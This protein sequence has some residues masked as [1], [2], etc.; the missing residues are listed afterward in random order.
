VS[1]SIWKK[2]ISFKKKPKATVPLPA[3]TVP[4]QQTAP[5]VHVAKS[6]SIWKKEIGFKKKAKPPKPAAPAAA[7]VEK[8]EKGESIWKKEIGRKKKTEQEAPSAAP[9][10]PA[11]DQQDEFPWLEERLRWWNKEIGGSR[12]KAEASAQ[13]A[14]FESA[15]QQSREPELPKMMQDVVDAVVAQPVEEW[16]AP[17]AVP[18]API[19]PEHVAEPEVASETEAAAPAEPEPE[20]EPEAPQTDEPEPAPADTSVWKKEIGFR[21]KPKQPKQPK[22]EKPKREKRSRRKQQPEQEQQEEPREDNPAE[23]KARRKLPNP[24]LSMPSRRKA[25]RGTDRLVGLKIG[26]SQIAAA[27]IANNGVAELVQLARAPLASGIVVG[28]ELRDPHALADSLKAFFAEHKLPRRGVRL[29]VASSRIGVRIF[30]I[31]A[32]D[33]ERQFLNAV[34]FR[35]QEALPIPLDEA[36]LDYRVLGESVNEEGQVIRRVLLVVAHKDLVERYIEACRLAGIQLAG[37]DLEAFA[38]LRSL[39]PPAERNGSALVAVAI[40]H[41]RTTLAVS[42]G[43]VCEFT[44]VLEWGGWAINVA[45]ARALDATPGEVEQVK[46]NLSLTGGPAPDGLAPEQAQA[47]VDAVRR[48]VEALARDLV[49][50][51]QYYQGQPGSLGIGEVMLTG[52]T[53]HLSGLAEELERLLGVGVRVGDPLRRLK[54]SGPVAENDIGSLAIAIGLGIED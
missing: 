45:L 46:R 4:A 16:G 42:D 10:R 35:A 30:E 3:P 50:S 9:L 52:G 7:P 39:A 44:R 20:P 1:D 19:E 43:R 26:G 8:A 49:S 51:L 47:A 41:E 12:K 53:A 6:E 25:S 32:I 34:R 28:G 33:D 2:E 31:P 15:A 24:R 48:S 37:I 29:G 40:G 11:A 22:Q 54:V 21:R 13:P 18:P 5:A 36:V 14:V 23:P 27:R 17:P 38:L